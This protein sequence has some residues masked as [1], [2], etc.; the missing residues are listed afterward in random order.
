VGFHGDRLLGILFSLLFTLFVLI[1]E[2]FEEIREYLDALFYLSF[3]QVEHTLC[4]VSVEVHTFRREI[5]I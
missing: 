2:H 3:D 1:D 5:V 4:E